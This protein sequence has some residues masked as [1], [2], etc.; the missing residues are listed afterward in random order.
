MTGGGTFRP[1]HDSKVLS[2]ILDHIDGD[3]LDL[4]A[5]VEEHTNKVVTINH[6]EK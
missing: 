6:E 4:K 5:L 2:A 3:V 1:G